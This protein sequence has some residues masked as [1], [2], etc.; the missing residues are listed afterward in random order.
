MVGVLVVSAVGSGPDQ[1]TVLQGGRAGNKGDE[2][3]NRMGIVGTVGK[4]TV[5]TDGDPHPRE[6]PQCD[7]GRRQRPVMAGKVNVSRNRQRS[8]NRT[9]AEEECVRP[10]DRTASGGGLIRLGI[11]GRFLGACRIG[12]LRPSNL[13]VGVDLGIFFLE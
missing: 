7:G 10:N 11:E 1:R 4:E 9:Q 13:R 2:S 5:V 3:P 6:D 8:E 12:H